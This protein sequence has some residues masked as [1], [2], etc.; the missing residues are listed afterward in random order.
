MLL[1][2]PSHPHHPVLHWSEKVRNTS[3]Q[4]EYFNRFGSSWSCER[5]FLGFF[6]CI[7]SIYTFNARLPAFN[8]PD[9]RMQKLRYPT[10]SV[11]KIP[12]NIELCDPAVHLTTHFSPKP[13][14]K[15]H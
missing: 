10:K 11:L 12:K 7:I 2:R 15:P 1:H 6:Y 4:I 9:S 13:H 8:L 3:Q 5:L 14:L